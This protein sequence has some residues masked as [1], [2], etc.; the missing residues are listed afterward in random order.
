M[1]RHNVEAKFLRA[2]YPT[3]DFQPLVDRANNFL[4]DRYVKK[5]LEDL[6]FSQSEQIKKVR[7]QAR[8]HW[9]ATIQ[10]PARTT[11]W[12]AAVAL[13]KA[14]GDTQKLIV[15]EGGFN[16]V[17]AMGTLAES[18][19]RLLEGEA[20][21]N[22]LATLDRV[23]FSEPVEDTRGRIRIEYAI[24]L[25]S[26]ERRQAIPDLEKQGDSTE[27]LPPSPVSKVAHGLQMGFRE[28]SSE[29]LPQLV[30][31]RGYSHGV[32]DDQLEHIWNY[33]GSTTSEYLNR[34]RGMNIRHAKLHEYGT[35]Q[36]P[37]NFP[38][39]DPSLL[40]HTITSEVGGKGFI[41]RGGRPLW[42]SPNPQFMGGN[43]PR[44]PEGRAF[45]LDD[46]SRDLAEH[47]RDFAD[48]IAELLYDYKT[49]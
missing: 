41:G 30:V 43:F 44:H 35:H 15:T 32:S 36:Y 19:Q 46:H 40:V 37:A 31:N 1:S 13:N 34:I 17:M 4:S 33:D 14:V 6:A 7:Y 20:F 29:K 12:D 5:A 16:G 23:H 27:P 26:I 28:I 25:E 2:A 48:Q 11:R 24:A 18:L 49:H 21:I 45:S 38:E 22:E 10:F 3:N 42:F 9:P 8:P 47:I 39:Q